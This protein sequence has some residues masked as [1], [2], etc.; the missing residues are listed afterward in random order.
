MKSSAPE[1]KKASSIAKI[2][3]VVRK[4]PLNKKE[5]PMKE[6]NIITTETHSSCLTVHKTKLK[7]NE[8]KYDNLRTKSP[9]GISLTHIES[10]KSPTAE[11]FDVDFGRISI[12]T[13]N[14]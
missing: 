1:K 5:L 7:V 8:N 4:T 14:T 11:L 13:V 12:V 6:E 3:V 9:V 2:K 10:C